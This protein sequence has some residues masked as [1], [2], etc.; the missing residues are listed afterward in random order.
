MLPLNSLSKSRF[1]MRE[2]E[3]VF[4]STASAS[5]ATM[6]LVA[7]ELDTSRP[8]QVYERWRDQLAPCFARAFSYSA[9]DILLSSGLTWPPL[10]LMGSMEASTPSSHE[11]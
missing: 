8:L 7:N 4:L 2:N 9:K 10:P 1:T 5:L 11:S 6:L 3:Q